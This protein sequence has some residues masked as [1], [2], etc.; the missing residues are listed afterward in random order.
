VTADRAIAA[1]EAFPDS[2]EL[3]QALSGR[4]QLAMMAERN[5]EA[6]AFGTRAVDLARRAGHRETVAHGL[7]NIGTALLAG[8]ERERGRDLLEE[9]HAIAREAGEDD[10]AARA[11]VNLAT[12][13]LLRRPDDP[14]VPGDLERAVA[15]ARERE[16]DGYLHYALGERANLRLLRGDWPGAE[17]DAQVAMEFGEHLGVGLIPALVAL[18]RLQARRGDPDACATLAWAWH[19][20]EAP[21]EPQRLTPAAAARAE[22][23]WLEGDLTGVEAAARPT[24]ELALTL[25]S[26]WP[27]AELAF[28]LWRAGSPVPAQPSDPPAYARSIAGDWRG[29]A[30][31]WE[32]IGFPYERADALSDADEEDA[33]LEALETFDGLWAARAAERLRARLRAS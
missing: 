1:L 27:R 11:L 8:R 16:L 31:A 17:A 18:G 9:V 22:H 32:A 19:L 13:E 26:D 29:A 7:T 24:H 14:R 30:A 10:H 23:A 21:G 20:A 2:V 28:W 15:F 6:I 12:A 5:E 25:A 33:R 4:S 3:A